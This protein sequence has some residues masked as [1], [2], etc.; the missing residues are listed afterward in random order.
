MYLGLT[1]KTNIEKKE[2]SPPMSSVKNYIKLKL[3]N[4]I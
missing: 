4:P 1:K 2:R 3:L